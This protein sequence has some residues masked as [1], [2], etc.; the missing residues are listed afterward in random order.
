MRSF[1]RRELLQLTAAGL[2]VRGSRTAIAAPA[3]PASLGNIA[4]KNGYLFGAAA[5]EVIDKDPAYRDLYIKQAKI[6]TTDVALK[7]GRVAP[8]PGP[9][10]FETADR[11]LAFCGQNKIAMRGHCLI[12]N[13][14]VPDWIK[15]MSTDERRAFFDAYID[16]VVAHYA[17]RLQSWD[18]VNEPF[19]PGHRAPGGFRLGPWY[20]AFGTDYIRRAFVRAA[21]T[22]LLEHGY[23]DSPANID[24]IFGQQTESATQAFQ[25]TTGLAN[26]GIVGPLTWKQLVSLPAA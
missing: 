14:W 19:W 21:Q 7:M 8:Q 13:E 20:D 18:V 25:K 5:A 16:E 9:K 3:P 10:H 4:A 22:E 1:S 17:G 24:G 26:D 11:L 23:L 15:R 2:A 12:W 6:I